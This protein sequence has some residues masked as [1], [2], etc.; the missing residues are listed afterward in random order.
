MKIGIVSRVRA[1]PAQ[2]RS[3]QQQLCTFLK[4]AAFLTMDDA[5]CSCLFPSVRQAQ[6][7]VCFATGKARRRDE[8]GAK[9]QKRTCVYVMYRGNRTLPRVNNIHVRRQKSSRSLVGS[10]AWSPHLPGHPKSRNKVQTSPL[11]TRLPV[12]STGLATQDMEGR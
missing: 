10:P 11:C 4:G 6:A 7:P 1:F 9:D 12:D 3:R 8:A 2:G 5:R